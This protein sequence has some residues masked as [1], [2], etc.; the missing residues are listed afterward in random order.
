MRDQ[1]SGLVRLTHLANDRYADLTWTSVRDHLATMKG[2]R[3]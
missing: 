2:L 3:A 1:F